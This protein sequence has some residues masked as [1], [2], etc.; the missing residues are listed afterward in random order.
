MG[1][2]RHGESRCHPVSPGVPSAAVTRW[3]QRCSFSR[4]VS[5]MGIECDPCG[6]PSCAQM[7]VHV[8]SVPCSVLGGTPADPG[9]DLQGCHAFPV[10][11]SLSSHFPSAVG[12]NPSGMPRCAQMSCRLQ[13]ERAQPSGTG[14]PYR[15]PA[16]SPSELVP[17]PCSHSPLLPLHPLDPFVGIF[18]PFLWSHLLILFIH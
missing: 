2:A 6:M 17:T 7:L 11:L 9:W 14:F 1:D 15:D 10:G 18:P 13:L 16:S 5:G 4:G 3:E 12:T 8:E